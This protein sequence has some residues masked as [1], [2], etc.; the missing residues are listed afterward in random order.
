MK[1]LHKAVIVVLA[2]VLC[3]A[4]ALAYG[5]SVVDNVVLLNTSAHELA[6]LVNNTGGSVDANVNGITDVVDWCASCAGGGG[7]PGGGVLVSQGGTLIP[8]MRGAT[9][10]PSR[11][12]TTSADNAAFG[13]IQL[14]Y[15]AQGRVTHVYLVGSTQ[16]KR[17]QGTFSVVQMPQTN[18]VIDWQ[19]KHITGFVWSGGWLGNYDYDKTLFYSW[20]VSNAQSNVVYLGYHNRVYDLPQCGADCPTIEVDFATKRIIRLPLPD[21]NMWHTGSVREY[22]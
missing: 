5:S 17:P 3:A 16:F 15:A 9:N 18:I 14:P 6:S 13:G 2:S 4:F 11:R 10:L 21:S 19:N 8:F 7:G 22:G 20:D 12:Y 1:E